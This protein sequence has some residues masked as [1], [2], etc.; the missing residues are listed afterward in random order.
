MTTTGNYES[1]NKHYGRSG[2]GEK[3]L[4]A[5]RSA[6]A[7]IDAL[8]LDDL[9]PVDE[10]HMGGREATLE[11]ARLAGI[12]KGERVLDIGC[13]IGGPAR[14]LAA[15][16]G[17]LVTGIDLTEEYCLAAEMLTARAGLGGQVG[18][19]QAGALDLP[20]G[21]GSFDV[22]W[23]QHMIGHVQDKERL[24]G[25]ARRVLRPGGRL[26]LF[27]PCLG[28]SEPPPHLTGG[29]DTTAVYFVVSADDY[30]SM[31]PAIGFRELIWRDATPECI[32]WTRGVVEAHK[33]GRP[34]PLGRDLVV[35]SDTPERR[36][37]TLR[38]METGRMVVVRAVFER[39][40]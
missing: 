2:L 38:N 36:Q 33:A 10:L 23:T 5:L 29:E 40:E 31:I 21:D 3:V 37:A 17:C 9:A 7:D 24:F 27:E 30:H 26:T 12:R 18:F 1:V 4:A 11:L 22:V 20:F 28:P 15:E 35:A 8:T 32:E 14:T 39:G 34:I 25:E 13:G 19:R 16:F 6:G